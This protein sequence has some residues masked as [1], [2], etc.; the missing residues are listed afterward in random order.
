M[1]PDI[2]K[3]A[4]RILRKKQTKA[5]FCLWKSIHNDVLWYRILRQKPIYVYTE[6]S[7]LDRY[8][9]ADFYIA[10]KKIVIEIDGAIHNLPEVL[11]LDIHKELL[12]NNRW[13]K[14]LRFKNENIFNNIETVIQRI[15]LELI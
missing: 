7:W 12:L 2:I 9:I 10:E 11:E 13:I 8:I 15:K 14:V 4:A 6:N 3:E 5:E 1:I